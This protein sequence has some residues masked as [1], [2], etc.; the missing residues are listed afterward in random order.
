MGCV[1]SDDLEMEFWRGKG[2][3]SLLWERQLLCVAIS[4]D[5]TWM[6]GPSQSAEG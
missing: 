5:V 1:A 4:L 6:G 3:A 2:R